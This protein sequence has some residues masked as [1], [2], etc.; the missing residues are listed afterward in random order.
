MAAELHTAIAVGMSRVVRGHVLAALLLALACFVIQVSS[1]D[2]YDFDY[3]GGGDF[4]SGSGSGDPEIDEVDPEVV[5]QLYHDT[6]NSEGFFPYIDNIG[7]SN[8]GPLCNDDPA[9]YSFGQFPR[10]RPKVL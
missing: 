3:A 8:R 4:E 2:D 7:P 6:W 1:Q 9:T 5:E 10:G